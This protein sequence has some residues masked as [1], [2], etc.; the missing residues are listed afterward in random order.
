MGE[1]SIDMGPDRRGAAGA[2][3]QWKHGGVIRKSVPLAWGGELVAATTR[4]YKCLSTSGKPRP[5]W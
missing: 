2:I 3:S 5:S 4:C 1:N